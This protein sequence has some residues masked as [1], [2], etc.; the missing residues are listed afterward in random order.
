VGGWCAGGGG[1]GGGRG[2]GGGGGGGHTH[3]D[4]QAHGFQAAV[5]LALHCDVIIAVSKRDL[6]RKG[7]LRKWCKFVGNDATRL[8]FGYLV[9]TI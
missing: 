6:G 4:A 8:R 1:G 2:G 3:G 9:P 5:D 7:A